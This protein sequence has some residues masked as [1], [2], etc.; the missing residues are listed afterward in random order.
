MEDE[1]PRPPASETISMLAARADE[2]FHQ[3]FVAVQS[4]KA[5]GPTLRLNA[6]REVFAAVKRLS[7]QLHVLSALVVALDNDDDE[8]SYRVATDDGATT[9]DSEETPH[10]DTQSLACCDTILEYAERIL[11]DVEAAGD[12]APMAQLPESSGI[13]LRLLRQWMPTQSAQFALALSSETMAA[14]LRSLSAIPSGPAA[15]PEF[16]GVQNG[17]PTVLATADHDQTTLYNLLPD[18]EEQRA[19]ALV[20]ILNSSEFN[21]MVGEAHQHRRRVL[22]RDAEHPL[23][24]KAAVIWPTFAEKYWTALEPEIVALFDPKKSFNFIQWVLEY[25]RRN[26]HEKFGFKALSPAP[27]FK[28]MEALADEHVTPLH[29][30]AALGLPSLC[31]RLL[32][33]GVGKPHAI[34]QTSFR[35][36]FWSALVGNWAFAQSNE[37]PSW[38]DLR[39]SP[40]PVDQEATI[41]LLLETGPSA[42]Q[43]GDGGNWNLEGLRTPDAWTAFMV[44]FY[45]GNHQLFLNIA[46]MDKKNT[47][48][49]RHFAAQFRKGAAVECLTMKAE[50]PTTENQFF[51]QVFQEL[52]DKIFSTVIEDDVAE[53]LFD[54]L[55]TRIDELKLESATRDKKRRLDCVSDDDFTEQV[56]EA[57]Q[58]PKSFLMRRIIRDPRWDPNLSFNDNPDSRVHDGG[59]VLHCAVESGNITTIRLLLQSGANTE[60]RDLK[61]RTPFLLSTKTEVMT[62]LVT[63]FG[64][65]T[66]HRDDNGYTVWHYNAAENNVAMIEWLAKNDPNREVALKSVCKDG[67]APLSDALWYHRSLAGEPKGRKK[68]VPASALSIIE[69]L[70][71]YKKEGDFF[72]SD[73]P[74]FCLAAEWG[75][76]ELLQGLADIGADANALDSEGQSPLHYLNFSADRSIVELLQKLCANVSIGRHDGK[77]PAETIFMNWKCFSAKLKASSRGLASP[78]NHPSCRQALQRDAYKR[79]LT[80]EV[81][82]SK[83]SSGNGLWVRFC[84]DIIAGWASRWE[85]SMV[86][87]STLTAV[88]CLISKGALKRYEDETK[89]C[90]LVLILESFMRGSLQAE[91]PNWMQEIFLAVL[92][93]TSQ[94]TH[95]KESTHSILSLRWAI[96]GGHMGLMRKLLAKGLSVHTRWEKVSTLEESCSPNHFCDP[97][98][99]SELLKHADKGKLDEL[100]ATGQGLIH[101]LIDPRVKY[102]D[103]KLRLLLD[104]GADPNLRRDGNAPAIVAYILE[105]QLDAA[106]I[107]LEKGADFTLATKEG[108]DAA[109]AAACRGSTRL[110]AK[111][112]ALAKENFDCNTICSSRFTVFHPSGQSITFNAT[113]CNALHMAAF[114]GHESVLQL[115]LSTFKMDANTVAMDDLRAPVHFA[116][117]AGSSACIKMLHA[118]GA[119]LEAQTRN[120]STALH[121]A[122]VNCQC[123]AVRTLLELGP[124]SP[125]DGDGITPY[126]YA[127]RTGMKHLVEIFHEFAPDIFP[128]KVLSVIS[129]RR[130][131]LIGAALE[132][133]ISAGELQTCR[134]IAASTSI[135]EIDSARL[136]CNGCTPLLFAIRK[137]KLHIICWL[138]DSG[139]RAFTG[140]C[141]AHFAGGYDALTEVIERKIFNQTRPGH[142]MPVGGLAARDIYVK[143]LDAYQT[144]GIW[145]FTSPLSPIHAAA[146]RNDE[147]AISDIISHIR[148][149]WWTYKQAFIPVPKRSEANT[150]RQIYT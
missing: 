60:A 118:Y 41:K 48:I 90:G 100:D 86:E 53:E 87:E 43:E 107:L 142:P 102:R 45:L 42:P 108:L 31:K 32:K 139:S 143:L 122:A 114:N 39:I 68:R 123:Y 33:D 95:F 115:Y 25:C 125:V 141:K 104:R 83:D 105:R 111:I 134:N 126:I 61:G 24:A 106:L 76:K 57:A 65:N 92:D 120:G 30:A 6:L 59:T 128:L 17:I 66:A 58:H 80:D 20:R 131:R 55:W 149:H 93:N 34:S 18:D 5:G 2:L 97:H 136:K 36:P 52:T 26:W 113:K 70:R 138:L 9:D 79:L 19:L 96:R 103:D 140:V 121:L 47:K 38:P 110:L 37:N 81:L 89:T 146:R 29:V 10:W 74:V 88:R 69:V 50:A 54:S 62:V 7:G 21:V 44:C 67:K 147:L 72:A 127:V 116:A 15:H 144:A 101:L 130:A 91:I 49:D 4:R 16:N 23:Y 150:F 71:S 73:V 14:F 85:S 135:A 94:L 119:N 22:A 82:D 137:S 98:T 56:I 1:N 46:S 148:E 77:T 40:Q 35:T 84:R 51:S 145:W 124:K 109:L 132:T 99:F 129:A 12:D 112:R 11:E 28:L 3:Y 13:R 117:L 8:I 27:R 133:A 64:A 63:E 78:T 75:E